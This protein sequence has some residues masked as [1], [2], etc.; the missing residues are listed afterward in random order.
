VRS[1]KGMVLESERR[2]RQ[3]G[4]PTYVFQLNWRTPVDGGKWKAP[5]T[6]DI[7]LVFDNAAYGASMIG[8]GPGAQRM[9]D[10]MSEA[11]IA[12]ARTGQPDTP[13]LPPWPRF[14]LERR[15]TMVFD[16]DP[17]VVDDPRGAERRLFAP[18]PYV[19]PGT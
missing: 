14:E 5:H 12:F 16:L 15:A 17:Q 2:A 18:V 13:H 19:Q 9:A 10:L 7:P 1:W 3:G 8:R 6:L 4:A 11:W